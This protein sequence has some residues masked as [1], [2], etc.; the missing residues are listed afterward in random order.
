MWV[1]CTPGFVMAALALK[2]KYKNP[3]ES[4]IH[5]SLSG[6]LCRCTGY[7]PIVNGIQSRRKIKFQSHKY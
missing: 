6:K 2:E 3:S 5:D 7:R 4:V 1:F